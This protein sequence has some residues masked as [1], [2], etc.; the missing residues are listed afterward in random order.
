[1]INLISNAMKYTK[2]GSITIELK[3]IYYH[4]HIEIL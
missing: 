1:M 4:Y 2:K 3:K